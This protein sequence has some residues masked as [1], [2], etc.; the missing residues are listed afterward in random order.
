MDHQPF[1]PLIAWIAEAGL[2]GQRELDLLQGF[3]ERAGA[4]G[5][6][7]RRAVL[8]VDTLHPVLEGR[9]FHWEADAAPDR[10]RVRARRPRRLGRQLAAK[11]VLPP[12][13]AAA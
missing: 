7:L 2:S 4:A 3:C 12:V 5:L 9:I 8:G 1:L 6:P 10:V 13:R 11:P